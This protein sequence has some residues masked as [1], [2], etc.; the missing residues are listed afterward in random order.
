VELAIMN[1]KISFIV[2]VRNEEQ[3]M[4][5]ATILGL[6][7]TTAHYE[8]EV[9]LID[10]GSEVP[11]ICTQPEVILLR[12]RKS[13]GAVWTRIHG[14]SI[15]SGDVLVWLD[16][17]MTFAP[18]WLDQMMANVD[19]G[20]LLCPASWDY[21]RSRRG[22]WGAD[23]GWMK[24]RNWAKGSIP[25][26]K[27]LYHTRIPGKGAVDVPMGNAS[28]LM[29]LSENYHKLGGFSPLFVHYGASDIDISIRAWMAGLGVKCVTEANVGH[30]YRSRFPY[31]VKFEHLESAHL[32]V[33]RTVF[34]EPTVKALESY[35]EPIPAPVTKLLDEA[36]LHG[37]RSVVQS[38]RQMSDEEFI[39]RIAPEMQAVLDEAQRP[40]S[41][42]QQAKIV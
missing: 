40:H 9:L 29:I 15:A 28:C 7:E 41:E 42:D 16:A 39:S 36:D 19:S 12:N 33:I 17:H 37:W 27:W 4:V 3:S 26:F 6:L 35:F 31:P 14:A 32:S 38:H 10:D 2:P 23:I 8:R 22:L 34:E 18:D 21:D 30:Y 5:D 25:G 1:H 11:V 24:E 20:A 13:I